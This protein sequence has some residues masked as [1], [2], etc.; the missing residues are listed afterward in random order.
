MHL[1]R[2]NVDSASIGD[3]AP[4]LIWKS[5]TDSV[6]VYFNRTWLNFTGRSLQDEVEGGWMSGLHPD[7]AKSCL[8]DYVQAFDRREKFR[9]EYRLRRYDGQYGW[10][11]DIAVPTFSEDLA[12]EGYIGIA[13]DI[14]EKKSAEEALRVS[15]ERLRLAQ[16]VAHI[17]TFDRN[18]RTG[19][20]TST[21]ELEAL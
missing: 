7:D 4:M 9:K 6:R 20:V 10:I 11:L 18:V 17:G 2:A 16:Q 14:T 3:T 12:F 8:E 19:Q 21:A 1:I 15:E 5:G 13:V